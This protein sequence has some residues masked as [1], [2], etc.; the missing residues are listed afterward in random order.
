[1]AFPWVYFNIVVKTE[2]YV[3]IR[4]LYG[5]KIFPINKEFLKCSKIRSEYVTK[6]LWKLSSRAVKT[7]FNV[8][9]RLRLANF[10]FWKY[11]LSDFKQ[12]FFWNALKSFSWQK[13]FLSVCKIFLMTQSFWH[14]IELKFQSQFHQKFFDLFSNFFQHDFQNRFLGVEKNFS[15][16]KFLETFYRFIL[17]FRIERNVSG[18]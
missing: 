1:M 8:S 11:F 14:E 15:R 2:I 9:K 4:K 6:C 13:C 18:I 17:T 3:S 10:S 5:M 12:N 7:D 16:I